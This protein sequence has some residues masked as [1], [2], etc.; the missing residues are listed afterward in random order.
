[1][2]LTTLPAS[3]RARTVNTTGAVKNEKK[4]IAPTQHT[5]A[6]RYMKRRIIDSIQ[7][8][9]R[10]AGQRTALAEPALDAMPCDDARLTVLPAQEDHVLLLVIFGLDE[11]REIHQSLVDILE[12][13]SHLLNLGGELAHP[14][15]D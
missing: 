5:I 15:G 10:N 12:E 14:R 2:T 13:A 3:G 8:R 4:M 9:L 11:K 1:M 6:S 7:Q